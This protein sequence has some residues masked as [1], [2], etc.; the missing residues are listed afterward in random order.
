[1]TH[2][3][4]R[5]NRRGFTLIELLVASAMATVVIGALTTLAVWNFRERSSLHARKLAIE[6][7]NNALE[8]ARARSPGGITPEWAKSLT[9]DDDPWLPDGKL[10]VTVTPDEGDAGLLRVTARV[11]WLIAEGRPRGEVELI[12]FFAA[13]AMKETGE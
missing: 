4:S 10:I 6:A 9:L 3:H 1:M 2:I 12:G 11:T 13:E 7:A 8:A 5:G